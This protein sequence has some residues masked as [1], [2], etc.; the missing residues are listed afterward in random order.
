MIAVQ[1]WQFFGSDWLAEIVAKRE[2]LDNWS[3]A[4]YRKRTYDPLGN[5]FTETEPI[6]WQNERKRNLDYEPECPQ[7]NSW[8]TV[9]KF[10]LNIK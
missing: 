4:V 5:F 1:G 2:N 7:R 6:F 8:W 10:M 3:F 9:L